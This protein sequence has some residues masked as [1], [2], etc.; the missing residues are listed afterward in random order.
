LRARRAPCTAPAFASCHRSLIGV[1]RPILIHARSVSDTPA[2]RLR[3]QTSRPPRLRPS[4][5][6]HRARR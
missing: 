1:R 6:L 2:V 3:C 4:P 5:V